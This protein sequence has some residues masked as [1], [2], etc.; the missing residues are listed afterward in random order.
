MTPVKVSIV[1]Y[2]NT[3]PFR[4]ALKQWPLK[5]PTTISEDIPSECARKLLNGEV[6]LALVP[7]AII[8]QLDSFEVISNWCIGANGKVDSVKLY[9][10]VPVHQIKRVVL[11]YQSRTSVAL[12]RVLLK[13]YWQHEVEF[14]PGYPGFENAVSGDTAAVIIG[15]RTF[16]INGQYAYEYDLAEAWK[17]HTGLPFVFA[18]WVSRTHLPDAFVDEFNAVQASGIAN[19]R[20][21]IKASPPIKDYSESQVLEYLTQRISYEL[22]DSKTQAMFLFLEKLKLLGH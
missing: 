14:I 18:A 15:D 1:N 17:N 19:I 3:L 4:W 12:T 7:V 21:A 9:A 20:E 22:D 13:E 6:D 8:N 5:Y 10:E 2:T 16:V 11:D